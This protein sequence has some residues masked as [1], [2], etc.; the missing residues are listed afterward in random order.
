MLNYHKTFKVNRA[1]SHKACKKLKLLKFT[2]INSQFQINLKNQNKK[3]NKK[4]KVI[5]QVMMV[6]VKKILKTS[7]FI[8]FFLL[9]INNT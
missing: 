3:K 8:Y 5:I 2:H 1:R 4:I 7:I 6:V 9:F